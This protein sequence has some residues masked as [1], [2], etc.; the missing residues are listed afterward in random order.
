MGLMEA[1]MDKIHVNCEGE[2]VNHA[3][4]LADNGYLSDDD[5]DN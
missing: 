4:W 1:F 5:I 2:I 3:D